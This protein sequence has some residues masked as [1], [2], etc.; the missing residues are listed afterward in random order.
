MVQAVSGH[1]QRQRR[2]DH[3]G[4]TIV[5]APVHVLIACPH[6]Q[7]VFL[8]AGVTCPHKEQDLPE[9]AGLFQRLVVTFCPQCWPGV[10]HD[11]CADAV[12]QEGVG[13]QILTEVGHPATAPEFY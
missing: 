13:R 7:G 2:R 4:Q 8:A 11:L 12:V 9:L 1:R 3:R 5:Q 10:M 6:H